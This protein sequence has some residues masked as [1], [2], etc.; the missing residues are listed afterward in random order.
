VSKWK[1]HSSLMSFFPLTNCAAEQGDSSVITR[2]SSK[3]LLW[4]WPQMVAHHSVAGCNMRT[5]DL[6]GSGTISGFEPG[7]QGCLLEQTKGGK[8][9]LSLPG[10]AQRTFINDGDTI[11]ITGYAGSLEEGAVGFGECRGKILPAV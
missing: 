10:G 2:T 4:S 5:G 3:N 8:T 11:T 9:P 7:T 1:P 6:F